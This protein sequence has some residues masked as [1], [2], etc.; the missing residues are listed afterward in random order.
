MVVDSV[1]SN[2]D[3]I[4]DCYLMGRQKWQVMRLADEVEELF[5]KHFAEED[6]RKAM[7]YL[8]PDQRKDSHSKTFFVG[9]FSLVN[10]GFPSI[11]SLAILNV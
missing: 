8:K 10:S 2:M 7:R 11:T 5:I 6:R 9:K 3:I 4:V 1:L